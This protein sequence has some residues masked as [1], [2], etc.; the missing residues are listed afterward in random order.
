MKNLFIALVIIF[1]SLGVILYFNMFHFA[2]VVS[3][4]CSLVAGGFLTKYL[5]DNYKK[6]LDKQ[7]SLRRRL[8]ADVAHELRTPLT[9]IGTH[10]EAM[11]TGLFEP[12]PERLQGCYDETV[13]LGKLVSDLETL[14]RSENDMKLEKAELDLLHAARETVL[15]WQ[16]E[17]DKKH[18]ALHVAGESVAVKADKNRIAQVMANLISNAIKY[19]LE[20][21]EVTI[22][23]SDN[24]KRGV[25]TVSDNGI[26]IPADDLPYVFERFYRVDKSRTRA[27][28]GSGIGLAIV[29]S[30]VNA[31][32][33]KISVSSSLGNGSTFVVELPK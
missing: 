12:T 29:K 32:G 21:G 2:C 22:F 26:G 9:S 33:G 31:H 17:A 28:G 23:I 13:R 16:A 18:I 19:T 6:A 11:M 10:L 25:I 5:T 7:E 14:A 4:V 15:T 27:S 20:N 8:T 24:G 30:I 1:A 3:F